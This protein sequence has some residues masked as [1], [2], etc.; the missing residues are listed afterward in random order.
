[1]P[2]I[3]LQIQSYFRHCPHCGMRTSLQRTHGSRELACPQCGYTFWMNSKPTVSALIVRDSMVLLTK[4]AIQPFKGQWDVPGGFLDVHENPVAGL[5][6]EMHEE[7]GI[8]VIQPKFLSVYVGL[9]PSVPPQST[10]NLYYFVKR[11]TGALVPQDDVAA[12][13]W[14]PLNRL[15]NKLAFANNRQALRDLQ[16]FLRD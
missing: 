1:M 9:Y 5:Q 13:A 16:K 10:L 11:F 2:N 6:R 7:L 14:H 3:K 12:F 15:P 4:R 8:R